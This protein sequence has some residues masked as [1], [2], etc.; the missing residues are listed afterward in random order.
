MTTARLWVLSDLHHEFDDVPPP[1]DIP[2][3]ADV[4]V[5]AGDLLDR[6]GQRSLDYLAEQIAPHLPVVF[7]P[8]NHEYYKAGL[9]EGR[10]LMRTANLPGVYVLD[11]DLVVIAGTRFIGATLWTDF[12][13]DGGREMNAHAAQSMMNDYRAIALQR[14]PWKRLTP[15]DTE[16]LH[17]ESRRFIADA[18]RIPFDGPTVVVTHHAPHPGSVHPRFKG[19]MLNAAFASDM[20]DLIEAVGPPLWVHGHMHDGVDYVVGET[21]ILANPKG[22]FAENPTYDPALVIDLSAPSP[23][24]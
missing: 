12:C 4:C 11:D 20:T 21:R 5:F 1:L 6:G 9:T 23:R 16:R 3:D 2:A 7:V 24:P 17:W 19:S 22:Y 14:N 10:H 8:G 18:L 15:T 13:L